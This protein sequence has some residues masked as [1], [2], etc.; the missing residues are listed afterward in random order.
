MYPENLM[1]ITQNFQTNEIL[2]AFSR[3][4]GESREKTSLGLKS[5]I[6]TII[7]GIVSK[8]QAANGADS[9]VNLVNKDGVDMNQVNNL[10]NEHIAN[11]GSDAISGL[12][13]NDL[14][15]VAGNISQK[16]KIESGTVKKMMGLAAPLVMGLIGSKMR[17]EGMSTPGLMGFLGQQKE[18]MATAVPDGIFGY[19]S[20]ATNSIPNST[21]N[22]RTIAEEYEPASQSPWFTLSLVVL[23]IASIVWWSSGIN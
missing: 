19:V 17:G 5:V 8:S 13:G 23:L 7:V 21:M 11:M 4:L 3:A 16:V 12:F 10:N 22:K 2:G 6:P 14:D 9:L 18:V 20:G 1:S 15:F